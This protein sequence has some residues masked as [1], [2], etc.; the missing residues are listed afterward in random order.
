[1]KRLIRIIST[2]DPPFTPM[3]FTRQP[4]VQRFWYGGLLIGLI[5]FALGFALWMWQ[6]GTLNIQGDYFFWKHEH[7]RL[8]IAG[9]LGSFLL[10]FALQS[11]PHVTGGKPPES[12]YLL[13]LCHLLWTGVAITFLPAPWSTIGQI[14]ISVTY[15]GAGLF[16]LQVTRAGNPRLRLPRG[17][18]L[19]AGMTLMSLS[20]WLPLD[21]PAIALYL[22]WCGPVTMALVAA[23][24]LIQNVIGGQWLQDRPAIHFI[25]SLILAWGSSALAAF[26]PVGSWQLSGLFW[27][28]TLML[29]LHGTGF[30]P[31]AW[32]LGWKSI[33]VTLSL[34]FAHA[35]ICALWLILADGHLDV[36]VHLLGAAF[37]TTLII[38]VT[39]R[40]AGF[41]SAGAVLSDHVTSLLLGGWAIIAWVRAFSPVWPM[42]EI[43]T[44][45]ISVGG[46]LIL[47]LWGVR[48]GHR[49]MQIRT[50]VPVALGGTKDATNP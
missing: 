39:V 11:G 32:R 19:A 7:A 38:G 28:T 24:Q 31:A 16:L 27:L 4:V 22:L 8:Q 34:G 6:H 45:W 43:W 5:G 14:M 17:Y 18:P 3:T 40:V 13:W 41:F 47:G 29:L 25:S 15:A 37:L 42:D 46:A 21:E 1:M 9:F 44:A 35:I 30:I 10:G 36:A 49:L 26:T 23:Q 50:L 2:N 12:R 33:N 20:P 48:T